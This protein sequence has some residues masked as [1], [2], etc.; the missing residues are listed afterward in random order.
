[1]K[2]VSKILMF[3]FIAGLFFTACQKEQLVQTTQKESKEIQLKDG[4]L[5]FRTVDAYFATSGKLGEMSDSERDAWEESLGFTS[6]RAE[7]NKVLNAISATGDESEINEIVNSNSDIIKIQNGE[8]VPKIESQ[9]YAALCNRSGIFYVEGVIHLLDGVRI[10]SSKDGK[11]ENVRMALNGSIKPSQP[12]VRVVDYIGSSS[13]LKSGECGWVASA[14]I[15]YNEDRKCDFTMKTF[16]EDITGATTFTSQVIVQCFIRNY[17]KNIFGNWKDYNTDCSMWDRGYTLSVPIVTG[18]DGTKSIFYYSTETY[19][20]SA[21]VS[22][23]NV[24]QLVKWGYV[25]DKVLFNTN[26]TIKKP[27]FDRVKG[28]ASNQGIAG[29]NVDVII[30]CGTW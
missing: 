15:E 13:T 23:N 7:I 28:K 8:V 2:N 10:A 26:A 30:R 14:Y 25:G 29:G 18:F 11:L 22:A 27:Y 4:A 6:L 1:M 19:L 17:K 5:S 9:S 20:L 12:G 16:S 3:I 24:G 21:K